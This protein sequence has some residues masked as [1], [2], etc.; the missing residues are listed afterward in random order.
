MAN[1]Q[2]KKHMLMATGDNGS[3]S[4][5][6]AFDTPD[7]AHADR[8]VAGGYIS[9]PSQPAAVARE[10]LTTLRATD[11]RV[12]YAT[13]Y[14]FP[15]VGRV[16]GADLDVSDDGVVTPVPPEVVT[17][18]SKADI[19]A[20][21]IYAVQLGSSTVVLNDNADRVMADYLAGAG[22]QDTTDTD[23]EDGEYVTKTLF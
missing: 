2:R 14:P 13:V 8:I 1:E 16:S 18:P 15:V 10:L 6:P 12:G 5:Q 7:P 20:A 3:V 19:V 11:V 22:V 23:I 9:G 4:W 17:Q 21:L